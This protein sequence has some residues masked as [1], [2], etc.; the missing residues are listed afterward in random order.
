MMPAPLLRVAVVACAG[1]LLGGCG[2]GAGPAAD[3]IAYSAEPAQAPS[4]DAPEGIDETVAM[5]GQTCYSTGAENLYGVRPKG[6]RVEPNGPGRCAWADPDG[7]ATLEFEYDVPEEDAW[8]QVLSVNQTETVEP[9][10]YPGYTFVRLSGPGEQD[11]P[12]WH[13]Q[14]LEG[15]STY[16][17]SF[18]LY[19]GR[20]R[21]TYRAE[22]EQF[23]EYIAE[24]L[25][26]T[27][28]VA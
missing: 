21:I 2:G 6:W 17:D 7:E 13:F 27:V 24:Q 14:Y 12:L 20:W 1:V 19:R 3:R 5:S 4:G 10:E 15:G 28:S 26:S 22:S 23:N 16:V 8:K 25:L 9:D 18:N 11:G